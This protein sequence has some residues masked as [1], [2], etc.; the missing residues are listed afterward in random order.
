MGRTRTKAEPPGRACPVEEK[1][2]PTPR[3]RKRAPAKPRQPKPAGDAALAG[4]REQAEAFQRQLSEA[5][6]LLDAVVQQ[7]KEAR[8]QLAA[9]WAERQEAAREAEALRKDA[10][11]TREQQQRES[12]EAQQAQK[13]LLRQVW[14]AVE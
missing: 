8:V 6:L 14:Q 2:S 7:S 1:T 4:V 5:A 13:L 12:A 3:T 9:V 11:A 10:A